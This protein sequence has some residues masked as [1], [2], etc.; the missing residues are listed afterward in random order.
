[1]GIEYDPFSREVQKDPYPYYAELRERAPA[2][3]V[4][5]ADAWAVSRYD[6][7]LRVLKTPEVFSSYAMQEFLGGGI[8]NKRAEEG[9]SPFGSLLE[10]RALIS[11]D[12]PD[13]T[14][15]RHLVNRGFTPQRVQELEPRIREI[16]KSCLDAVADR[17]ELDLMGDFAI[18]IP[19]TVIAELLGIPA[20]RFADFK[21]WSDAIVQGVSLGRAVTPTPELLAEMA[22]FVTFLNEL[23]EARKTQPSNDLVSVLVQKEEGGSL[24]F[25]ELMLFAIVLLVAGNETT[26][27]LVGN[28]VNLLL[29]RPDDLAAVSGDRNLVPG[30]V[31]EALRFVSPIQML[32]RTTLCDTEIAGQHI[33][34]GTFVLVLFAAANRDSRQF[35]RGDDFELRRNPKDHIAFGFGI[36]YCL[37]AAL[38]RL[39]GRVAL[40]ELFSRLPNLRRA[41][42]AVDYLESGIL[43]G[44]KWLPVAFD[45]QSGAGNLRRRTSVSAHSVRAHRS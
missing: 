20:E 29:D 28:T 36:H 14:R 16:T 1:M 24:T 34:K 15:L 26:T 40:E 31:E 35:P 5:S 33:D 30:L 22:E 12:P 32:P 10:S 39:E 6:D 4:E 3:Y 37:G 17:G 11:A 42:G 27:N 38:A 7:V 43:R 13:H 21:R 19:V 18:P 45:P 2:Y 44:P 23:V 25:E 9:S 8:R 41:E